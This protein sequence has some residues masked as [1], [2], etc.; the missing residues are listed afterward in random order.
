MSVPLFSQPILTKQNIAYTKKSQ[1]SVLR[2][3]KATNS[4]ASNLPFSVALKAFV[5]VYYSTNLSSHSHGRVVCH[6]GIKIKKVWQLSYSWNCER[7]EPRSHFKRLSLIVRVN[8]VL[9]RTVFV[10]SDWRFD[11]LCGSHLQSQRL[12]RLVKDSEDDYRTGCR[13]VSHC[14]Q[15]QSYS[16]LRSPVRSNSTYLMSTVTIRVTNVIKRPLPLTFRLT[17]IYSVD[18]SF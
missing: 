3:N 13:N 12:W 14:K 16:G 18:C 11:N 5:L 6:L 2:G 1:V 4:S 8:V 15:Q 17:Y 7:F 10:D 9:N